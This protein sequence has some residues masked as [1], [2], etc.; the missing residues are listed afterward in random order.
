MIFFYNFY[1]PSLHNNSVRGT[2]TSIVDMY[3]LNG[4][5][6]Y[7]TSTEIGN[8]HLLSSKNKGFGIDFN[9]EKLKPI[10]E[11]TVCMSSRVLIDSI[12]YSEIQIKCKTLVLLDSHDILIG[13]LGI[14]PDIGLVLKHNPNIHFDNLILLANPSNKELNYSKYNYIEYYHK[15]NINRLNNSLKSI[16]YSRDQKEYIRTFNCYTENIGKNLIERLI[17]NIPVKYSTKGKGIN[18]GLHYYLKYLDIDDNIDQ[19]LINIDCSKL[20]KSDNVFDL[21][22]VL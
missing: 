3:Y 19:E 10:N 8:L 4:G 13:N 7:N 5:T 18:D 16:E 11:E 15:F 12:K 9:I 14:G 20:L 17:L 22:K 21:F 6:I 2:L 1:N